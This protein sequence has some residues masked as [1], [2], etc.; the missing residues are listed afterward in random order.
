MLGQSHHC[1]LRNRPVRHC[2]SCLAIPDRDGVAIKVNVADADGFQVAT[3]LT[4]EAARWR[5][6]LPPKETTK[7]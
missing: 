7:E 1:H 5:A 2:L 3:A 4:D 6:K